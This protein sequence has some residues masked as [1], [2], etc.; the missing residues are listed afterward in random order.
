[1]QKLGALAYILF[2]TGGFTSWGVYGILL[3]C[4]NI[5]VRAILALCVFQHL[6][7]PAIPGQHT[8]G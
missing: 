2:F 5:Y 4:G 1:M 3:Y 8:N 6:P 7:L